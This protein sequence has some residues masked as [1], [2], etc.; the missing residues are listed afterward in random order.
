MASPTKEIQK[1]AYSIADSG[2]NNTGT[3]KS[4]T[5]GRLF[6]LDAG[7]GRLFSANPDSSDLK[8]IISEGR[9]FPDGLVVDA[10]AGHIYWTNM[11]NPV[12]NDGSIERATGLR[13]GV[14]GPTLQ[15][16][17]GGGANGIQ[18]FLDHLMDPLAGL[19]KALGTPDVTPELKKTIAEGVSQMAGDHSV[20]QLAK[21]E[22]KLLVDLIKLR[23]Q[24]AR[25]LAAEAHA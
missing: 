17:L 20:E 5:S 21:E 9:K 25:V 18:H 4:K 11:G 2:K 23:A 15:W 1:A 19:M 24:Q 3:D 13:W 14:M 7:G 6:F 22:N 12:V 8:A 16:H 10:A